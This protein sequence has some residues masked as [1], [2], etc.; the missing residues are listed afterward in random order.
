MG[1]TLAH[2]RRLS[3]VAAVA[4]PASA[5]GGVLG[6]VDRAVTAVRMSPALAGYRPAVAL[7]H[8]VPHGSVSPQDAAAAALQCLSAA[9]VCQ[10]VNSVAAQ[11]APL[12]AV[13]AMVPAGAPSVV[14][15]LARPLAAACQTL[16][17]VVAQLAPLAAAVAMFPAGASSV[18]VELA[19]PLAA[20][21]QTLNSVAA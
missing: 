1:S 6:R 2:V 14:V 8:R 15:E 10:T 20:A 21:C 18:V 7:A 12:A 17:S 9:A 13:V 11:L 5:A 3:V 19:R 16:N 4:V